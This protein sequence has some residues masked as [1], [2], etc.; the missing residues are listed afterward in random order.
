MD[1][2]NNCISI[3]GCKGHVSEVIDGN[4]LKLYTSYRWK[5]IPRCTGRYTSAANHVICCKTPIDLLNDANITS[6]FY[7]SLNSDLDSRCVHC[8][9]QYE[10]TVQGK[11]PM[12]IVPIDIQHSC[13][14][15]TYIKEDEASAN[16]DIKPTH[17]Y[18]HTLNSVS[19]FRRKL[20]ALGVQF[21]TEENSLDLPCTRIRIQRLQIYKGSCF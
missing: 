11:D 3:G 6:P 9:L 19:G 18:I 15:I 5:M 14:L 4:L 16:T 8:W 10:L 2:E 13:G 12:I 20:E 1:S 21:T 7:M 17:R